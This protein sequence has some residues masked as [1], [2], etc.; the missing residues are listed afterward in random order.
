MSLWHRTRIFGPG[1]VVFA[2][3]L[4]PGGRTLVLCSRADGSSALESCWYGQCAP[5][6]DHSRP[7]APGAGFASKDHPCD[8]CFDIPIVAEGARNAAPRDAGDSLRHLDAVGTVVPCDSHVQ[9]KSQRAEGG[10]SISAP[11]N[12]RLASLKVV[13]LLV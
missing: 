10:P 4:F 1:L 2:T 11:P 7:T 13:M 3:L 9:V 12:H 6:E 5:V 8:G